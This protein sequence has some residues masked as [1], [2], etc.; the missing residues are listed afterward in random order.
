MSTKLGSELW[1]R[2]WNNVNDILCENRPAGRTMRTVE[3]RCSWTSTSVWLVHG[4]WR[5][6][7]LYRSW[8][9]KRW[10]IQSCSRIWEASASRRRS[11]EKIRCLSIQQWI[12][13]ETS[14]RESSGQK[15]RKEILPL[16]EQVLARRLGARVNEHHR[17][18][19]KTG[20]P[21]EPAH[22]D[23]ADSVHWQSCWW[24]CC[25]TATSFAEN[26]WDQTS[27]FQAEGK[28]LQAANF[29]AHWLG[30]RDHW[31]QGCPDDLAQVARW[32]STRNR[33]L[34]HCS[35]EGGSR[36]WHRE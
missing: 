19:R 15:Y 6:C 5:Y 3:N 20:Q 30:A 34:T 7:D 14:I 9:P 31:R 18:I 8:I 25:G 26:H 22:R 32:S 10:T 13:E 21:G 29:Q 28:H 24:F 1:A 4:R 23:A 17:A 12:R 33:K 11:M 16:G 27:N 35:N 36:G 2:R